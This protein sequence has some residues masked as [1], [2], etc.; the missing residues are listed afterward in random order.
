MAESRPAAGGAHAGIRDDLF[1]AAFLRRIEH[2]TLL[3]RRMASSG[4]RAARRSKK[5]GGGIEFADH[6][7]YSPGDDLRHLDWKVYGR[8]KRMLLRQYEEEE[9]LSV[10]FLLDRSPS[11]AM[12]PPGEPS[13][14][15]RALQIT[16]A[17]A[18]I[19]LGNLDRVSVAPMA[20]GRARPE[21]PVRGRAQL[22][23]ILRTLSALEPAGRTAIHDS[24]RD[25]LRFKPRRGL[26]V[27][28]SD[29]YDP[30]G[31]GD[32]LRDLAARGYEPMVLQLADERLF[33]AE[34]YGDLTLVDVETGERQEIWLT[35][36]IV[37]TYREVFEELSA[38]VESAAREVGARALR[39][40][41]ATPFDEV[42]MKI[43]RLGGFLG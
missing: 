2:L 11:M 21:R 38:R 16:A 24:I 29:L 14:F 43:F 12:A 37:A 39:V 13:L 41:V 5:I 17:L 3:A 30:D 25:F 7:D 23:R 15:D 20:D 31:L 42:V 10:Y 33:R 6:R 27:L 32:G 28:I 8:T 1:D 40:D 34:I 22:F 36:E 9:D 19:A 26:V 18:Y 4:Q 35:P